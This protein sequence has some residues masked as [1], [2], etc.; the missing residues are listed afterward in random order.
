VL[1]NFFVAIVV[2]TRLGAKVI[3]TAISALSREEEG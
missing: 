2:S 1:G 3:R